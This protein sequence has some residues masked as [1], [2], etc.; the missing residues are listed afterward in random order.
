[1]NLRSTQTGHLALGPG[2]DLPGA[3][4]AHLAQQPPRQALAMTDRQVIALFP[5][6]WRKDPA[7]AFLQSG[8]HDVPWGEP[9]LLSAGFRQ[10][11][12]LSRTIARWRSKLPPPEPA[13][14]QEE[15]VAAANYREKSA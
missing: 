14:R 15:P 4:R 11:S 10:P 3:L 12:L 1:M 7:S 5:G 6:A 13:A 9:A 2:R 8:Y